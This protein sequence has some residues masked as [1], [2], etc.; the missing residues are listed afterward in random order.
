MSHSWKAR[1]SP[2]QN[3]LPLLHLHLMRSFLHARSNWPFSATQWS[4]TSKQSRAL[5][6]GVAASRAPKSRLTLKLWFEVVDS[7]DV[8]AKEAPEDNGGTG[9]SDVID[10]LDLAASVS[11]SAEGVVVVILSVLSEKSE[12]PAVVDELV[13]AILEAD[14]SD[15]PST[16]PIA[17]YDRTVPLDSVD[18][19]LS[20]P[21]ENI[22]PPLE[23]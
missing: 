8:I 23:L 9:M 14:E 18:I 20:A 16:V 2:Q 10:A 5:F 15:P 19:A 7:V 12:T 4:K 6:F 11:L 22:A 17:L 21:S 3:L 13:G 1:K